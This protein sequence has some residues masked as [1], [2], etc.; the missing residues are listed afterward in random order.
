M[1][2]RRS[3]KFFFCGGQGAKTRDRIKVHE[4]T[5]ALRELLTSHVNKINWS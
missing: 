4:I 5:I 2:V 1:A 3:Y